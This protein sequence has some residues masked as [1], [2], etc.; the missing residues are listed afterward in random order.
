MEQLI[1]EGSGYVHHEYRRKGDLE[2]QIIK[3]SKHIFG[4]K[5]VYLDV[6]KKIGRGNVAT[7]PDGYLI[8]FSFPQ[9]KLYIVKVELVSN[10]PFK[11]IG[12]QLLKFAV[13][14]KMCGRDIKG[15]LLGEIL[16]DSGKGQVVEEGLREAG[17]GSIDDFLE[18]IVFDR[19]VACIV[20]VDGVASDLTNVL[21][22]LSMK[23]DV[24]EFQTF[25]GD[26]Y[27]GKP[28]HKF[29][30]FQGDV[31]EVVG[32]RWE[33][34]DT[35]VVPARSE[36][37]KEIFLG[38]GCW[39]SVRVSSSM[40]DKIKYIAVYR[41]APVSAVT[42]YAEVDRIEKYRGTEK[43]VVYFKGPARKI[44]SVKLV[45]RGRVKAPR[46]PRYTNFRRL[47]KAKTLDEVF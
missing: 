22:Q 44:N 23:T 9:P 43:Y 11:H 37:F 46:A 28:I 3:Y 2:K 21:N 27:Y 5:T 10:D 32:L 26:D 34:L 42:H 41:A 12:E 29:T 7:I 36:G 39:H 40:L 24:V 31:R 13:S 16:S 45:L 17:Y 15:F 18:S 47:R 6:K 30:P 14:Y 8:D 38:E 19:P 4:D 25:I 35:I 33:E 20:V 1:F